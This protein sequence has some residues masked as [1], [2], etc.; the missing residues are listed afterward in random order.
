MNGEHSHSPS[1]DPALTSDWG[2]V[3]LCVNGER[4]V[5][6]AGHRAKARVAVVIADNHAAARAPR[7]SLRRCL[8][9][10][11]RSARDEPRWAERC[12]VFM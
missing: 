4:Q 9:Y 11:R 5:S 12:I 10:W 6:A 7:S 3:F 2:V 1:W 8:A